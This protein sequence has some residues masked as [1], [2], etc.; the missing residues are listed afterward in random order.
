MVKEVSHSERKMRRRKAVFSPA[1]V[2][3]P[4][5][6]WETS[7]L[8]VIKL[9]VINFGYYILR[10]LKIKT[11]QQYLPLKTC[12]CSPFLFS[13]RL[14]H[15][16]ILCLGPPSWLPQSTSCKNN[17]NHVFKRP[18]ERLKFCLAIPCVTSQFCRAVQRLL[19][20][21]E[22]NLKETPASL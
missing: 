9:I 21:K 10:D 22:S 18:W 16:E 8:S 12:L 2:S 15:G 19:S 13:V 17:P 20:H 11:I 3:F 14:F 6:D 5:A 4:L 1:F 7:D